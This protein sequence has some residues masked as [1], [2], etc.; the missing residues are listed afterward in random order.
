MT[1]IFEQIKQNISARDAAERY[2]LP[3]TRYGMCPCPFHQDRTPSMK[4]DRRYYCFGCHA[5]G[6]AVDLT[7]HLFG[8]KPRQAAEKL[9][10]DFGLTEGD[11]QSNGNKAQKIVRN[12]KLER[13]QWLN[14]A[15]DV[16]L[17]YERLLKQW[18]E[19]FAP[20]RK[21]ED[22]HPLFTEALRELDRIQYLIDIALCS[23]PVELDA[24]HRN[25]R[26]EVERI[27][28]RIEEYHTNGR[29]CPSAFGEN[30]QRLCPPDKAELRPCL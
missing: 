16:L 14:H 30:R 1:N 8:L 20:Q 26:K 7:A 21:E 15:A 11:R 5:T 24:F 10:A 4:V 12:E 29:E 27:E 13:R 25:Y 6:D 22:L 23:D 9:A 19:E 17:A 28:R 18:R 2:G 3:V